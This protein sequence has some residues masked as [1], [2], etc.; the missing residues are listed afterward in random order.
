MDSLYEPFDFHH[1][2]S[3]RKLL[4]SNL[5]CVTP[6]TQSFTL[7]YMSSHC[8]ILPSTVAI[9]LKSVFCNCFI[10]NRL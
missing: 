8:I 1:V 5:Q 10:Q 3:D 7:A 2:R 9:N 6:T 4:V